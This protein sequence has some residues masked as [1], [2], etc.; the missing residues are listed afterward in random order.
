MRTLRTLQHLCLDEFKVNLYEDSSVTFLN[1]TGAFWSLLYYQLEGEM[2][3]QCDY[4][5]VKVRPGDFY[6]IPEKF[7]YDHYSVGSAPV[8]FYTVAFSFRRSE[9]NRFDEK[10][11]LTQITALE[12]DAVR[13]SFDKMFQ[14]CVGSEKDKLSAVAEFYGLFSDVLPHLAETKSYMIPPALSRAVEYINAHL[15]DDFSIADLAAHCF[16]S[17][18]TIYHLF[19]KHFQTSPI[20]YKNQ[21]KVKASF[22]L[23]TTTDLSVDQIAQELNFGTTA[24]YRNAFRKV[25]GSTPKRYRTVFLRCH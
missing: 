10:Y 2:E 15:V 21:R 17:E 13:E 5:T 19:R 3:L 6:F 22:V 16:V 20:T 24:N 4:F 14:L 8:R 1:A 12:T 25:T 11:D 9:G 18:S 23:L 7:R